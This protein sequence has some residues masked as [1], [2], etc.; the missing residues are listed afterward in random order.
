V[1]FNK[2]QAYIIIVNGTAC[3]SLSQSEPVLK[4]FFIKMIAE[5]KRFI[6]YLLVMAIFMLI[7]AVDGQEWRSSYP[8]DKLNVHIIPHTHDDPGWLKTYEQYY[9]G[10]NSSIYK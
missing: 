1:V 5:K 2:K 9:Y 6:G 8:K 3:T 10:S 4:K 7:P